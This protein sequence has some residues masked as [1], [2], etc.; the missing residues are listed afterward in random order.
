LADR[1]TLFSCVL[2]SLMR[3]SLSDLGSGPIKYLADQI[4]D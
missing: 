3:I 1:S 4:I 2:I